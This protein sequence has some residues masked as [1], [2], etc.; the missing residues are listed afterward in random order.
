MQRRTYQLRKDLVQ[1]RR[2][3]LPMRELVNGVLRHRRESNASAG[4]E[5]LLRR[6]V[7]PRAAGRGMDRIAP[8]HGH[9]HLRNQP[10]PAGRPAEH[11]D[12]ETHRVGGD[13]RRA[14]R[15]HRVLRAEHAL[16]RVRPQWGFVFSAAS[17]III[18]SG[19][20][21]LFR[22]KDWL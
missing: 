13:H 11:G 2:V 4:P 19:L 20:Y 12:E 15:G 3:T 16:P 18:A 5:Q 21:L 9:H 8:R 6:P 7:R 1:L 14:D 10:V 22:R 17:I